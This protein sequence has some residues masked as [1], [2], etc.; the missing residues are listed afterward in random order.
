[1]HN[2]FINLLFGSKT[3]KLAAQVSVNRVLRLSVLPAILICFRCGVKQEKFHNFFFFFFWWIVLSNTIRQ[4]EIDF[5][6]VVKAKSLAKIFADFKR[7]CVIFLELYVDAIWA[8][9]F[10]IWQICVWISSYT[11]I[12][13]LL[14]FFFFHFIFI[15][16]ETQI[17]ISPINKFLN[18]K[19]FEE[20]TFSLNALFTCILF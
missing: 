3:K 19:N 18:V 20:Y 5:F 14:L 10:I 2:C 11:K 15:N 1:M 16:M 7:I 8:K 4:Q 17:Q 6:C 12:T 9:W 13:I